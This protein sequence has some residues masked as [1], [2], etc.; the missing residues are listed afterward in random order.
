MHGLEYITR[1]NGQQQRQ[2]HPLRLHPRIWALRQQIRRMAVGSEYVAR[3]YAALYQYADQ[4]ISRPA[5]VGEHGWDD[6]EAL[7][8]VT[9]GDWMEERLMKISNSGAETDAR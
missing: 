6:L 2:P 5:D 3:L 8:Q 7:Q 1:V 4:I 9:L